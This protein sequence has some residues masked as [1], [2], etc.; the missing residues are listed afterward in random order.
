MY[1]HHYYYYHFYF[2]LFSLSVF[3]H[4][5]A[6]GS[7]CPGRRWRR[8][9]WT[10]RP[11]SCASWRAA[12]P[13]SA[14]RCRWPTTGPWSTRAASATAR[15]TSPPTTCRGRRRPLCVRA[16]QHPALLRGEG[17]RGGEA[18]ALATAHRLVTKTTSG[19]QLQGGR[20]GGGAPRPE[21]RRSPLF[22]AS[23]RRSP[24]LL[25]IVPPASGGRPRLRLHV[26]QIKCKEFPV[27]FFCT[28]ATAKKSNLAGGEKRDLTYL[29][30]KRRTRNGKLPSF[31]PELFTF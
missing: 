20:G 27:Y 14:S 15:D 5:V 17:V 11:T 18:V 23:L 13:A 7:G 26:V 8:W 12:S 10:T 19:S 25:Q 28:T 24:A 30:E 2:I 31:I 4:G 21:T 9:A 6:A 22:F 29:Y 3:L 1:S 16:C